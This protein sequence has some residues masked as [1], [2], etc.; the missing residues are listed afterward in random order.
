MGDKSEDSAPQDGRQIDHFCSTQ[1]VRSTKT[2]KAPHL[3]TD[4]ASTLH[5]S[6]VQLSCRRG[7]SSVLS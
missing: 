3:R 7:S 6:T 4:S 1:E 5:L 2:W